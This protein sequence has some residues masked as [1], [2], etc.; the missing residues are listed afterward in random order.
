MLLVG[1]LEFFLFTI[2]F[3]PSF[4]LTLL[5]YAKTC[6]TIHT[7]YATVSGRTSS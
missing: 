6:A 2:Q 3:L 5:P 1:R 4:E 7:R